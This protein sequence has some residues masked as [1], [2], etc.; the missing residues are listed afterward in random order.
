[1]PRLTEHGLYHPDTEHDAC[2]VGFVAQIKGEKSR[3]IVE[4]G[5]EVLVRLAH[6]GATGADPETGDG[7][8][9]MLQLPHRYYK[10]EGLELGFDMPRRRRYG[11]GM[12][13]LPRAPDHRRACEAVIEE[14]IESEGQRLLGWRDVPVEERFAGRLAREVM[15]TIRQFYVARRRLVPTAFERKLFVIRK[16]ITARVKDEGVDPEGRFHIASLSADTI[17]YKGLLLPEQLPLFYPDLMESDMV[18]A[19][20]LVHSRFS[21]NTFPTWDLAQP[22]HYIAHN[23]EINTLRGNRNW[24]NARRS[25][26]ESAKFGGKLDRLFPI[27]EPGKSDSAQFDN[28]LELLHLGGRSLPQSMMMLIPEAWENNLD[29]PTERREFYE[30]SSALLEPWDGPAA[31]A[32]TDGKLVGATLDRNGLRPARYVITDDDRVILASESGVV[33]IEPNRIVHKGRLRPGRM[34]V[35]DTE[36]QRII[37]DDEIKKDVCARF[38]YGKWLRRNVFSVAQFPAVSPAEPLAGDQLSK[39]QRCFGYTDETARLL[40]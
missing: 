10:R 16:L 27:I 28:M 14:V 31:I 7:A 24:M 22:F 38:P 2:G 8:G 34:F 19:I 25:L 39:A 26:L 11:V 18:S 29:M 21:T 12:V 20:A 37:G 32:F 4:Q 13:F 9:I 36:E 30:Y 3:D 40:I 23:G 33:D 15:P 5:L 6:R 17:T 1:M 35:V